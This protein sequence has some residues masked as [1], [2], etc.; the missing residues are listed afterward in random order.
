MFKI[1]EITKFQKVLITIAA[2]GIM[3]WL[4]GSI[5]RTAIGYD[6][7]LPG[8]ELVLKQFYAEQIQIHTVYLYTITSLYTGIGFI[9]SFLS[10]IILFIMWRRN[11]KIYGWLF[12]AFVLFFLAAPWQLYLIYLDIRLIWSFNTLGYIPFGSSIINDYFLPQFLRF[13]VASPLTFLAIL[14]S[15]LLII[16]RPLDKSKE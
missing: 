1:K 16:W 15:I 2:L 6:L 10:V 11:L 14:T 3:I 13:K 7:F 12:M 5:V 8:T 4:G 9:L